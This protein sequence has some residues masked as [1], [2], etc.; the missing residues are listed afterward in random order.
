MR[1]RHGKDIPLNFPFIQGDLGIVLKKSHQHAVISAAL[2]FE[3][4]LFCFFTFYFK[5]GVGDPPVFIS[6]LLVQEAMSL[7]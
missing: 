2:A 5:A 4:V 7:S 6:V 1:Q 3:M